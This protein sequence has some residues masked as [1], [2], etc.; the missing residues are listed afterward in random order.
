MVC[1]ERAGKGAHR[2]VTTVGVSAGNTIIRFPVKTV[3]RLI[4][5]GDVA[6]YALNAAGKKVRVRRFRCACGRATI[7]TGHDDIADG[8]L[9]ALSRCAG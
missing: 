7:R 6:F 5:R 4:K 8:V 3:R 1:V 9:S 2:H